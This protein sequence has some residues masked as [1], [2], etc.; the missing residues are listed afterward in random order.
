MS[1]GVQRAMQQYNNSTIKDNDRSLS[2]GSINGRRKIIRHEKRQ[3]YSPTE[4]PEI[5]QRGSDEVDEPPPSSNGQYNRSRSSITPPRSRGRRS[6]IPTPQ[7]SMSSNN[8]SVV[9]N[10]TFQKGTSG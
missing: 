3:D 10:G 7:R 2:N 8:N 6:P 4:Y 9:M 5:K 1:R